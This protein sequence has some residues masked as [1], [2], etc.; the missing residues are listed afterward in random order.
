VVPL[1]PVARARRRRGGWPR[2]GSRGL[3]NSSGAF[4]AVWRTRPWASCWRGSTR[5]CRT[6]RGGLKATRINSG[7]QSRGQ[8]GSNGQIKGTS[9]LLTSSANSGARGG[10]RRCGGTSG[11]RRRGSGYARTAPVSS[12]RANQRGGGH[13]ERCPEQLMAR[14]NSPRQRTGRGRNGDRRTDSGRR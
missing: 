9:R 10:R 11:Q 3:E 12:D 14:R 1:G 7:K 5:G 6:R 2:W 4:R 8:N 13:T